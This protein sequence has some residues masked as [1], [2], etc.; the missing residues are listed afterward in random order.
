MKTIIRLAAL[1][2]LILAAAS[3]G[4][5][6]E[7]SGVH[8]TMPFAPTV[9]AL[10]NDGS[11][12]VKVWG[13]GSTKSQAIDNALQSAVAAAIYDGFREGAGLAGRGPLRPLV[14]TANARNKFSY[15]FEPFFSKGGQYLRYVRED[16]DNNNS[17]VESN[18]SGRIGMAVVAVVERSALRQKLIEDDIIKP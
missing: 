15:Y 2:V 14:A 8:A 17:R 3:C 18:T 13:T 6:R 9:L 16:R 12:V 5:K 4:T 1:A 11:V 7:T 10:N